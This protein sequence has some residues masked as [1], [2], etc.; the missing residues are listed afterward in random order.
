MFEFCYYSG[1]IMLRADTPHLQGKFIRLVFMDFSCPSSITLVF[2]RT[3][4]TTLGV[5]SSNGTTTSCR[6]I[7]LLSSFCSKSFSNDMKT[8]RC[9]L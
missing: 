7:F 9:F 3:L 2:C 4:C 5:S 8:V 1:I 6:F